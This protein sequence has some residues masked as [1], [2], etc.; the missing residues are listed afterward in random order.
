MHPVVVSITTSLTRWIL[1][2]ARSVKP[3]SI[4]EEI[5]GPAEQGGLL[6]RAEAFESGKFPARWPINFRSGFFLFSFNEGW[7]T[8]LILHVSGAPL[9]QN[10]LPLPGCQAEKVAILLFPHLPDDLKEVATV[11]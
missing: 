10:V 9:Q 3:F 1:F 4:D 7:Y 8:P 6:R 5:L 2:E 11:V